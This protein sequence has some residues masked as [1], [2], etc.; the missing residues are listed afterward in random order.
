MENINQKILSK[1]NKIE[2]DVHFIKENVDDGEF[3]EW[4]KE[5]LKE[6]RRERK[7]ISHEELKKELG[8]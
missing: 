4:A 5:E 8:L 7:T 2:I 1:L 3:S 6:A